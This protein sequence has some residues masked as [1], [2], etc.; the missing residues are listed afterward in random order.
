MGISLRR[1]VKIYIVGDIIFKFGFGLGIELFLFGKIFCWVVEK[2]G[3]YE[4]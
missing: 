1:N 3:N 4:D 2:K